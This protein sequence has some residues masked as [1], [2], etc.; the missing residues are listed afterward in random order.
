MTNNTNSIPLVLIIAM[1]FSYPI[2]QILPN[3]PNYFTNLT[4]N[5]LAR[6]DNQLL[7]SFNNYSSYSLLDNNSN[8]YVTSK[9][10]DG[11]LTEM[12][13]ITSIG[14]IMYTNYCMWL[15]L[16]SIIL[17]LAMIGAIVI[18]VKN[19]NADFKDE[20]KNNVMSKR[21]NWND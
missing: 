4:Y 7:F 21:T 15:I 13:H 16:T 2:Q 11:Y 5:A 12:T 8:F 19:T 17:L 14:N 1:F 18:T 9:I 20:S 6:N 10:W 3:S